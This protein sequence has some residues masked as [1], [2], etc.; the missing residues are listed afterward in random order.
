MSEASERLREMV[1]TES[2]PFRSEDIAEVLDELDA[3]K[4]ENLEWLRIS[5]GYLDSE[6]DSVD[7]SMWLREMVVMRRLRTTQPLISDGDAGAK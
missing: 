4:A 5:N 6:F 1:K 2:R 7:E 3:L